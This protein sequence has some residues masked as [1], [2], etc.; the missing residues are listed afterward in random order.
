MSSSGKKI[1]YLTLTFLDF[2]GKCQFFP[3]IFGSLRLQ[4]LN[5]Q[6]IFLARFARIEF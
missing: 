6:L 4:R 2:G 1:N 3:K 5:S